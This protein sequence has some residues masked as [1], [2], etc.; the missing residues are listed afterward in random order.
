[1]RTLSLTLIGLTLIASLAHAQAAPPAASAAPAAPAAGTPA[2]PAAEAAT[3]DDKNSAAE[4]QGFT[5]NPD[6]RRDPLRQPAASGS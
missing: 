5:Y 4:P 2:T 3:A 1:M 6:G